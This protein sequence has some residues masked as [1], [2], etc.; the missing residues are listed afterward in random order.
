MGTPPRHGLAT[1]ALCRAPIRWTITAAGKRQAVDAEPA[2]LGNIGARLDHL[3]VWR[4]RVVTS[5]DCLGPLEYR[6]MP[7]A[8]TCTGRQ[9]TTELPDGLSPNA[10]RRSKERRPTTPEH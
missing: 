2:E 7:H 5:V 6:F 1:C 9:L 8:A 10:A 4:S 3:Q